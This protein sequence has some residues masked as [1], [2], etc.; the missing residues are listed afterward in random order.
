MNTDSPPRTGDPCRG[1]GSLSAG[2]GTF[3]TGP[4]GRHPAGVKRKE[5][6]CAL[7]SRSSVPGSAVSRSPV[8][9]TVH[10]IPSTIYESE[11]SATARTQG[12]LLDIRDYNGQLA[13]QAADLTDEFHGI[14][15]QGRQAMRVLD[16][17]GKILLDLPDVTSARA[18][19]RWASPTAPP[20]PRACWSARTAPGRGSGGC[21]PTRRPSTSASR[22]SRPTCSTATPA[23]PPA[24]RPSAPER[25]R[26][27]SRERGSWLTGSATETSTPG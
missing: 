21:C 22:S 19:T 20:S 5:S 6:R 24:R 12:G 10:G 26:R 14:V 16:R 1:A 11:S 4:A 3:R 2:S 13:L 23:T 8:S 25:R 27:S 15:L 7:T 18:A 9:C 17:N